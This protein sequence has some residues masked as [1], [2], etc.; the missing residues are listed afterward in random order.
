MQKIHRFHAIA[1]D[2]ELVPILW[3]ALR[4]PVPASTSVGESSTSKISIGFI[5]KHP[6]KRPASTCR[7]LQALSASTCT[8]KLPHAFYFTC[9][10]TG[11]VDRISCKGRV[12]PGSSGSEKRNVVPCP[13]FRFD[14]HRAAVTLDDFFANRQADARAGIFAARVQTLKHHPDALEILRLDARPFDR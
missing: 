7:A 5:T 13:T 2:M 12:S 10:L 3:R 9:S 1:G 14:A 11:L 6:S 4:L 8:L